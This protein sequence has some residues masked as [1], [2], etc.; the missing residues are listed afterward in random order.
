M[1]LFGYLMVEGSKIPTT[2]V[3]G[4]TNSFLHRNIAM[5]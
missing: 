3:F 4:M 1:C 2:C 5:T